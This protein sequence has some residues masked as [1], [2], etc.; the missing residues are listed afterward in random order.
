MEKPCGRLVPCL[1]SVI[2]IF[3]AL[4]FPITPA[5]AQVKPGDK[6]AASNAE[7]VRALVSPGAFEAVSKGMEMNIVAP[8]R[9]DWPPPYQDAT[10]KYSGQVRLGAD[11]RDQDHVEPVLQADRHRRLRPALF[12]MPGGEAKSRRRSESVADDRARASRR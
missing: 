7:Q 2:A 4:T 12:R 11:N 3:F 10:E 6:I 8:S 1:L 9:V 5:H